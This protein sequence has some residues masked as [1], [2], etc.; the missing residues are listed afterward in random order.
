MSE[1][2]NYLLEIGFLEPFLN[3]SEHNLY[4]SRESLMINRELYELIKLYKIGVR[5]KNYIEFENNLNT[6]MTI[7]QEYLSS[8]NHIK[9]MFIYNSQY[10]NN[11]LFIKHF[12]VIIRSYSLIT[13]GSKFLLKL[14]T[15]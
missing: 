13:K 15:G 9:M 6:T 11:K 10:T 3:F 1:N 2:I 7:C 14:S 4:N 8:I 5:R 12:Q